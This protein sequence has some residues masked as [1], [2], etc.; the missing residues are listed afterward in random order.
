MPHYRVYVTTT[1]GHVTAPPTV[2]E[3][4][5]DPEAIGKVAQLTNGKCVELWEGKRFIVRLPSSEG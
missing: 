4:A 3:C 5:D 2:I 1:D